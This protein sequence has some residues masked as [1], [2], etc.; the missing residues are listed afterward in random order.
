M[1]AATA[2]PCAVAKN[3]YGNPHAPRDRRRVLGDDYL[4]WENALK[5]EELAGC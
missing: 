2:H 4:F 1:N 5:P 3:E